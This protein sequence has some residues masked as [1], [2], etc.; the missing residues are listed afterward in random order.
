MLSENAWAQLR[1][2]QAKR[3]LLQ[4][5]EGLKTKCQAIADELEAAGYEV[6]VSCE[7]NFGAC[8]IRDRDAVELGCD[9]LLHVGHSTFGVKP[10]L[11]V[12]YEEHF[13]D[14]D[15]VPLLEKHWGE[16]N[17][18]SVFGLVSSVQFLRALGPAKQFLEACGKT[19]LLDKQGR[20][21]RTGAILGCDWSAAKPLENQID[22]FLFIGSGIFHPLGL[23]NVTEKTVLF[24]NVESGE[25]EDMRARKEQ[26]ERIRWACIAKARDAKNFGI[27]VSIK[28][29]QNLAE[30]ALRIK[31]QLESMDK[32]AWILTFDMATPEKMMG[33]K[34]DVLV[35]TMCPRMNEDTQLF[36]KPIL[37]PQDIVFL[38][39]P[40]AIGDPLPD[41][42][43]SRTA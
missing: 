41:K 7:P 39:E 36:R 16:L 3:V 6:L 42:A 12:I 1:E 18:F 34:L 2:L 38:K 23:A 40:T 21:G 31:K 30:S 29:G 15:P 4:F 14:V 19:V 26:N 25:L 5:P 9:V 13:Y 17:R 27:L 35:N 22:A 28:P 20:S 10:K 43:I 8:D 37:N 24:L 32:K 11:P 33:L